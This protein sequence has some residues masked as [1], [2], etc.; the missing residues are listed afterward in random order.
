MFCGC[1]PRPASP[2]HENIPF[3]AL[4]HLNTFC[5]IF[6]SWNPV[7]DD[8][9]K[10]L[11]RK[12]EECC[13]DLDDI[14]ESFRKVAPEL[15]KILLKDDPFFTTTNYLE[16]RNLIVSESIDLVA[17]EL[18]DL[19]ALKRKLCKVLRRN[20]HLHKFSSISFLLMS[21]TDEQHQQER[22]EKMARVQELF[23]Q[24]S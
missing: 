12:L 13:L 1:I 10:I 18:E 5:D 15:D 11:I 24:Y 21:H 20:K 6:Y 9:E 23:Q 7:L 8:T 16:I 3:L 4:T 22:R 14:Y 17:I 19:E 2:V